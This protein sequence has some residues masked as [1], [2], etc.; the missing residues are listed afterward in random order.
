MHREI[1]HTDPAFQQDSRSSLYLLTGL[2]GLIIAADLWPLL[3]AWLDGYGLSLPRWP[4]ELGGSRLPLLAAV[5]GGLRALYGSL[6]SLLQG[7]WGADLALAIAPVAAILVR[8]PL[9][10][11]EIV[12]VGLL[13]ECLESV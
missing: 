5:L 4:N 9:V 12:F 7:K 2:L 13:G 1:S 10:A 3:A 6:A 11:A 8:E